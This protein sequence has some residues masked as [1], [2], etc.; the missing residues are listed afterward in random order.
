MP[1]SK[2]KRRKKSAKGHKGAQA[3][4]G[5]A[6]TAQASAKATQTSPKPAPAVAKAGKLPWGGKSGGNARLINIVIAAAVALGLVA[7]YAAL[8]LI[9]A[10]RKPDPAPAS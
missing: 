10:G 9:P 2:T 1:K 5:S 8:K 4:A 7:L 3:G 6:K